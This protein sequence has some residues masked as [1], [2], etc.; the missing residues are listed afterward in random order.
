[1]KALICLALLAVTLPGLC[2]NALDCT[3]EKVD[4]LGITFSSCANNASCF[5]D[6][7]GCCTSALETGPSDSNFQC[8][9][10]YSSLLACQADTIPVC[11]ECSLYVAQVT[12]GS[13][14]ADFEF[15]SVDVA[16][17]YCLPQVATEPST[18]IA[19]RDTITQ[20]STTAG[21]DSTSPALSLILAVSGV[22]TLLHIHAIAL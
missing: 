14:S 20:A 13:G 4:L 18:V 8:C 17:C 12:S 9:A 5:L 3:E 11:K 6:L 21:K 2:N 1:M 10:A 15:D 19:T 16:D 22:M 7:C